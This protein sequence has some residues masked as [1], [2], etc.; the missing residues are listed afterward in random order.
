MVSSQWPEFI[1]GY[2]RLPTFSYRPQIYHEMRQPE[3]LIG[4]VQVG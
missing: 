3:S 4:I 2:G 1:D